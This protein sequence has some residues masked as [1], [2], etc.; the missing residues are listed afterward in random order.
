MK[1]RI[2]LFCLERKTTR[3]KKMCGFKN[4]WILVD[5]AQTFFSHQPM[6]AVAFPFVCDRWY[7]AVDARVFAGKGAL[8]CV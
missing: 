8:K 5:M 1:E 7:N 3:V 6:S 2:H 4:I